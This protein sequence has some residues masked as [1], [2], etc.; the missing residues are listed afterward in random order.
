MFWANVILMTMGTFL[1]GW[2]G[3]ASLR[4]RAWRAMGLAAFGLVLNA[5]LWLV[6]LGWSEITPIFWA[7]IVAFVLVAAFLLAALVKRFPQLPPLE[8]TAIRRFDERDH[9]FARNNT[10]RHPATAAVYYEKHPEKIEADTR[11]MNRPQLGQPGGRYYDPWQTPAAETAFELLDRSRPL[12]SGS[13]APDRRSVSPGEMQRQ[14]IELA[15]LYGAVDVGFAPMRDYHCYSHAGRHLADW[16]REIQPEHR[17][18]V[19]IVVAMDFLRIKCAPA[20]PVMVESSRQYVESAKIA[21]LLAGY[22]RG[23]GHEARAHVDGNYEVL[24]VPLAQE[25]GLGH[26]GRMSLFMHHV[27]GPCVRL[28]VVTTSLELP[29]TRREHAY[30][31]HFCNICKKCA[32]NCPSRAIPDGEMPVSRGFRHWSVDQEACYGF[33][34]TAGTDCAVCVRACPF[35]KP[36]TLIHRLVRWYITRNRLNQRLALWADDLFYGR[37]LRLPRVNPARW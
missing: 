33:W 31:A 20:A 17:T 29:A 37:R 12:A 9:M 32:D 16:G 1:L 24:C 6:F 21:N 14:L 3:V 4:E 34:R 5:A 28:A 30:M 10:W 36:D 19:V 27:Y 18:A 25:A 15:R 11:I 8:L 2:L 13:A 23:F 35:T 7:N 22:I 26:V